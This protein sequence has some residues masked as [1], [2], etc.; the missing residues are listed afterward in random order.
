M[1][2]AMG[3]DSLLHE[4][5]VRKLRHLRWRQIAVSIGGTLVSAY[6]LTFAFLGGGVADL[7]STAI[8][9]A[10]TVA[11]L[12]RTKRARGHWLELAQ[13]SPPR[14]GESGRPIARSDSR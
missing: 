8:L 14:P 13:Q 12:L 11:E 3:D 2:L 9:V 10:C 5:A 1:A 4:Q 6:L 7:I